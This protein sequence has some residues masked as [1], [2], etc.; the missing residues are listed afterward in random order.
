MSQCVS[1][2]DDADSVVMDTI[3]RQIPSREDDEVS[4]SPAFYVPCSVSLIS[5]FSV[6][7]FCSWLFVFGCNFGSLFQDNQFI[8]KDPILFLPD[9]VCLVFGSLNPD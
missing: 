5:D 6:S 1:S 3:S 9:F 2:V 7:A 8:I 4:V